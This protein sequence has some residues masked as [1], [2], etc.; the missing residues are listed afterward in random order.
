MT[1]PPKVFITGASSGLGLA[2]AE[3]YARQGAT[4][5]LVARRG[6]SLAEFAR[7]HPDL[8]ISIHPADVRDAAALQAAA[9]AF[10]A[11]HGWPDVVIANAGISK[12]RSPA[13]ATWPPSARSWTSTTTAW[14]PASSP[15]WRP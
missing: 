3:A 4:L 12:G 5:G 2:L 14:W 7:R 10:V 1:A 8:P 6:D 9:D 11:A 13:R 15:S